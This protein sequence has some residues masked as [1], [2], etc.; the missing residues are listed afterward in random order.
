MER[1]F[2]LVL[3][4]KSLTISFMASTA[5][6][7]AEHDPVEFMKSTF[8]GTASEDRG[9]RSVSPNSTPERMSSRLLSLAYMGNQMKCRALILD[10]YR[11]KASTTLRAL[12]YHPFVVLYATF[13][14]DNN[15]KA[16]SVSSNA[17]NFLLNNV[18]CK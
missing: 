1:P 3:L 2:C 14:L 18:N 5:A 15:Y 9:P 6:A 17:L 10:F 13:C 12:C 16:T 8:I 4:Y 11:I 7:E